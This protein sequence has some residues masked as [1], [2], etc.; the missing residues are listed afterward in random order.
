VTASAA[1]AS[2]TTTARGPTLPAGEKSLL[3]IIFPLLN[4][5]V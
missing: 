2:A 3:L 5:G 4:L 1:V